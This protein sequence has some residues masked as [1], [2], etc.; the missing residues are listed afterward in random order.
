[1]IFRQS[2]QQVRIPPYSKTRPLEHSLP[3]SSPTKSSPRGGCDRGRWAAT[4]QPTGSTTP[5]PRTH[6]LRTLQMGGLRA[7]SVVCPENTA[8]YTPHLGHP[9][10]LQ[11]SITENTGHYTPHLGYPT[12][13]Q[14]SKRCRTLWI[15]AFMP[16]NHT[17]PAF[18]GPPSR[19]GRG[20]F[21]PPQGPRDS[22]SPGAAHT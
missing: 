22:T 21:F 13:P 3:P 17:G 7:P 8:H 16:P 12:H 5:S 9:I 14:A 10:I 1:M 18:R 4:G 19:N 20:L 15:Q 6:P 2:R 11:A